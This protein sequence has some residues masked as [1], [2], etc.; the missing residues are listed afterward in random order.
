MLKNGTKI[1]YFIDG[2][3]PSEKDISVAEKLD[4][5]VVFRNGLFVND[6]LGE[7]QV[8]KCD[9]VCGQVPDIYAKKYKTIK[10]GKGKKTVE[11]APTEVVEPAPEPKKA[12]KWEAGK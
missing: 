8:E 9:F 5:N 7:G 1:L 11:P 3:T 10:P 12:V 4:G 2:P 6:E